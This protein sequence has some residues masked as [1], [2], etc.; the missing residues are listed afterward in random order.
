MAKV[1]FDEDSGRCVLW[2]QGQCCPQPQYLDIYADGTCYFFVSGEIGDT[3][4]SDVFHGRVHRVH[5]L[6]DY[7]MT[8]KIR[9]KIYRELKPLLQR[10]CNGMGEVWNENNYI[11]TLTDDAEGALQEIRQRVSEEL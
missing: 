6:H 4:S 11:G 3:C 9:R 5:L 1:K 7:D 10:V 8:H 2:Y